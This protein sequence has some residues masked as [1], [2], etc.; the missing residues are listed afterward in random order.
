VSTVT[1]DLLH[2][3][4]ATLR[5]HA[6]AIDHDGRWVK[7]R[8]GAPIGRP[9]YVQADGEQC[10]IVADYVRETDAAYAALVDPAVALAIADLLDDLGGFIDATPDARVG[11]GIAAVARAVLREDAVETEAVS[12]A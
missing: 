2:R 11:A 6:E 9:W 7:R 3:A 12:H 5:E 10:V 8:Y 4:A 1:T